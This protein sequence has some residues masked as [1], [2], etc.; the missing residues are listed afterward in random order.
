MEHNAFYI[1]QEESSHNQANNVTV[2]PDHFPNSFLK[3]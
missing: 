3:V 2:T 1:F